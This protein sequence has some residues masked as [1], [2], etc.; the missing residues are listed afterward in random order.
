MPD[1]EKNTK[2]LLAVRPRSYGNRQVGFS[3]GRGS[4][5]FPRGQWTTV[6]ERVKL[7]DPGEENGNSNQILIPVMYSSPN[8]QASLNSGSMG[9]LLFLWED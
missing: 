1:Y 9:R 4:F 6:A 3:V 2:A 8:L 7:N 5:V